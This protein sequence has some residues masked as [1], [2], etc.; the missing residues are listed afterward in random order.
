MFTLLVGGNQLSD[1]TE[2]YFTPDTTV[3]SIGDTILFT[4]YITASDTVRGFTVYMV[5]DTNDVDLAVVPTASTLIAGLPGLDFRYADHIVAAPA[6]LEVGATVFG[7]TYWAG[8]GAVFQFGLVMR[9]CGD[10]PM[11]GSFGMRRPNGSFI[12]GDF[13]P[14]R[15]FVCDPIPAEPESLTV[16]WTGTAAH[17]RW[18]LV[19]MNTWG[20]P[21][22]DPPVYVIYRAEEQPSILPYV[23]I[24]TV[25]T[26]QYLDSTGTGIEHLYY[27]KA[28]V[29]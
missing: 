11:T 3:A 9:E 26:T 29:E 18:N 6:W 8:P 10:I 16:F 12:P 14:P 5:Y 4:A 24:D 20:F 2:M 1:A 19:A 27:V 23:A 15:I 13:T 25:A 22:P 21:L 7:T 28:L 17:L